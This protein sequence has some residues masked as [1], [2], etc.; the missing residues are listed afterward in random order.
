MHVPMSPGGKRESRVCIRQLS[1]T[2]SSAPPKGAGEPGAL[3][4]CGVRPSGGASGARGIMG[5]RAVLR[6]TA[7]MALLNAGADTSTIALWLGHEQERTT[8][9]YLHADLALK[10]RTLDRITPPTATPA[11][12]ARPTPCLPSSK[13]C[14]SPVLPRRTAAARLR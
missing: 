9:I 13:L 8:H 14:S 6:H 4:R 3:E 12:T 1:D 5:G 11:A 2:S 7:A 10:H